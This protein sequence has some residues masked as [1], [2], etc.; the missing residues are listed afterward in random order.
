ML[1]WAVKERP[2][3]VAIRYPR[4]GD[5]AYTDSCWH[6]DHSVCIHR[7]GSDAAIITYGTLVNQAMQ[8]AEILDQKGVDISVIR[9]TRLSPLPVYEISEAL[10]SCR[11]VFVMEEIAG[12]CGIRDALA[13]Q[14]QKLRPDCLVSGIDLGDQYIQHGAISRLYDHYGLSGEKAAQSIVEVFS[15]ED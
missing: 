10:D 5:G 7:E 13:V 9:L 8:A 12:N 6:T 14:L 15:V 3:P 4:G 1:C 11:N 2:G